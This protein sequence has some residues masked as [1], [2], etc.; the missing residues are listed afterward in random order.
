MDVTIRTATAADIEILIGL[1]EEL[2]SIEADFRP[3]RDRQRRGLLLMLDDPDHRGVLVAARGAEVVGM[4]T[5]QLVISTVEGGPAALVEDLVVDA[6]ARGAGIG[7]RLVEAI[8]LWARARGAS[9]LQLLA[10][11]GNGPALHFY[12]RTGWDRTRLVGLRRGGVR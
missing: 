6:T 2:F 11:A 10:D 5:A 9:R 8:A 3:D 12:A 7:R 4:I 1:L